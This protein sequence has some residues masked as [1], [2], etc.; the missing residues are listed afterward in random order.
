MSIKERNEEAK[1]ANELGFEN[2]EYDDYINRNY[3]TF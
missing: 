3:S 2:V 1:L